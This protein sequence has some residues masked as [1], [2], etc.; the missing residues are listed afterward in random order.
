MEGVLDTNHENGFLFLEDCEV[1]W[2]G[3]R[4]TV[5]RTWKANENASEALSSSDATGGWIPCHLPRKSRVTEE[6]EKLTSNND[7][8]DCCPHCRLTF[9]WESEKPSAAE[10]KCSVLAAEPTPRFDGTTLGLKPDE[11]SCTCD[12]RSRQRSD[13]ALLLG[14]ALTCQD[15]GHVEIRSIEVFLRNDE[16]KRRGVDAPSSGVP[17]GKGE[18][19]RAALLI[20]VSIPEISNRLQQQGSPCGKSSRRKIQSAPQKRR[21]ISNSAK[22]LPPATQLLLSILRSDWNFVDQI[23]K[24]P[25]LVSRARIDE[26]SRCRSLGFFPSKLSLD[27]VYQRI[28]GASS[29]FL[30][31]EEAILLHGTKSSNTTTCVDLPKDIWQY[32]IGA[33]LHAKSLDSLRCSAKYFHR[34]LQAV[35][36]GLRLKLY[37]H[38]VKSLSWMRL[39]ETRPVT[40]NELSHNATGETVSMDDVHSAATG[41]ATVLLRSRSSSAASPRPSVHRISQYN[42]EE[43]ILR[44]DDPLSRSIARGGLLC[45]DPGLGKTITV[46]SL[47]LQTLG[48]STETKI[49]SEDGNKVVHIQEKESD[50]F[51]ERIFAEYW[52]EQSIPQ[53]RS[54]ALNKL[55]STFIR[56]NP[57]TNIFMFPVDPEKDEAPDYFDI[58]SNPICFKDVRKRINE[59]H[60]DDAFSSFESDVIQCFR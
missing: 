45:D 1:S 47:I 20:I 42:G 13:G 59:F 36:P 57:A 43:V 56:S 21:F 35:V 4:Q 11:K 30:D 52:R 8:Q 28:G 17:V 3:S 23:R 38:Q 29:S 58:I 6:G 39:R 31:R 40:E 10:P 50:T 9:L 2:R 22:P 24:H 55:F 19:Q 44:S 46:L 12:E 34:I 18:C 15:M 26:S 33:F 37:E 49:P 51:E 7:S 60:Y 41:G 32:H 14:L 25:E 53:F 48:L 16:N 5:G 54:Q 27:E